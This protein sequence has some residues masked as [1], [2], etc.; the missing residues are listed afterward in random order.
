MAKPR[1]GNLDR[2]WKE[3]GNMDVSETRR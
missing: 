3:S 1:T 2:E